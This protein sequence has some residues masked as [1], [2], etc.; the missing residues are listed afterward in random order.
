MLLIYLPTLIISFT[1]QGFWSVLFTVSSPSIC[2]WLIREKESNNFLLNKLMNILGADI[3]L[4]PGT[5]FVFQKLTRILL[6]SKT[7]SANFD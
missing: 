7:N 2:A 4:S 5:I 3:F 6:P 1:G